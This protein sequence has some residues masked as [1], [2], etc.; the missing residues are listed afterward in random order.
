VQNLS[1]NVISNKPMKCHIKNGSAYQ[2]ALKFRKAFVW[3]WTESSQSMWS[4]ERSKHLKK[5]KFGISKISLKEMKTVVLFSNDAL[6]MIKSDS[7]HSVKIF[8]IQINVA[9][10]KFLYIKQ[11]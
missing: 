2:K 1:E 6:K 4:E 7:K 11:S 3:R 8:I 10:L 5:D 9:L